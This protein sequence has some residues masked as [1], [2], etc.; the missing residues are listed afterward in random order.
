MR[1]LVLN[2]FHLCSTSTPAQNGG[3]VS[4]HMLQCRMLPLPLLLVKALAAAT[5]ELPGT[6]CGITS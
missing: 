1:F 6:A 4:Q 2:A 5:E 3:T